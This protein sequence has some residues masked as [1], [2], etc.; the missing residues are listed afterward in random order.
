MAEKNAENESAMT[1]LLETLGSGVISWRTQSHYKKKVHPTGSIQVGGEHGNK[2]GHK[3]MQK[4]H[5]KKS[6]ITQKI[7]KMWVDSFRSSLISTPFERTREE[8]NTPPT[9]G[10]FV[11]FDVCFD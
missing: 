10:I 3:K 4:K 9:P 1:N 5:N 7:P 6:Q 2:T 8:K 11:R